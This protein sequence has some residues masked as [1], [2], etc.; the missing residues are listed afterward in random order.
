MC[1]GGASHERKG[2]MRVVTR[3]IRVG[4]RSGSEDQALRVRSMGVW[5]RTVPGWVIVKLRQVRARQR[6]LGVV[7]GR[8][9]A[10]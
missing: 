5:V 3:G 6:E 7:V 1:N 4:K 10:G 2:S 8:F 9:K